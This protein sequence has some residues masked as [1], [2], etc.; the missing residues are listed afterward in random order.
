[1]PLPVEPVTPPNFVSR[2][3]P[4]EQSQRLTRW[5]QCIQ[6]QPVPDT[7]TATQSR[8]IMVAYVES[9]GMNGLVYLVENDVTDECPA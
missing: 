1:M 3:Q 2:S 4:R 5:M 9:G 8:T 6:G 7:L